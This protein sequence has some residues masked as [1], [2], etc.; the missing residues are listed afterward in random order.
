[1]L[2]MEDE[3]TAVLGCLWRL[4]LGIR[5]RQMGTYILEA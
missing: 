1:M 5:P 3:A 2:R 4:K